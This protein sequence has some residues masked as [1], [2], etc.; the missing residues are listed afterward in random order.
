MKKIILGI[1]VVLSI[2]AIAAPKIGGDKAKT[3]IEGLVEQI[4]ANPG[5][6]ATISDYQ[7]SWFSSSATLTL[8]YAGLNELLSQNGETVSLPILLTINHGPV[9]P[10]Q[11]LGW[12]ALQA[13]LDQ[14]QDAWLKENI[15]VE[16]EGSFYQIDAQMNLAGKIAIQDRSLPFKSTLEDSAEISV[17]AWQG[18]GTYSQNELSYAGKLDTISFINA[19]NNL[20]VEN[21][22][23]DSVSDFKNGF[24]TLIYPARG[25]LGVQ[26]FTFKNATDTFSLEQ[27]NTH[28]DLSLNKDKTLVDMLI[29]SSLKSIKANEYAYSDMN[30]E[31]AYERIDAKALNDYIEWASTLNTGEGDVNPAVMMNFFETNAP[32]VLEKQPG[33]SI[34]NLRFSSD[35]GHFKGDASASVTKIDVMPELSAMGDPTFWKQHLELSLSAD[36][37]KTL[38]EQIS[39]D[40]TRLQLKGTDPSMNDEQ[41]TEA[42][43]QQGPMM[44]SF[45]MMSGAIIDAETQYTSKFSF[46][47]GEANLNG[48]PMPLPF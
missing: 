9:I 47:K 28:V 34:K 1:V 45:A 33:F 8:N 10:K 37:D 7:K 13:K 11:G 2:G 17:S 30:V 38:A 23:I 35:K 20:H 41:L 4:N 22:Y 6:N 25:N 16:G 24:S 46:S 26:A 48:N 36:I 42:A 12:F 18:E 21:I 19:E 3:Q 39:I 43:Q 27:F 32:L 5:M 31:L 14:S 15:Q 40:V 29:G 44:L